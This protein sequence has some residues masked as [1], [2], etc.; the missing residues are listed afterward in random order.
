MTTRHFASRQEPLYPL[1]AFFAALLLYVL[2]SFREVSAWTMPVWLTLAF[3][4]IPALG[5]LV[6]GRGRGGTVGDR[7]KASLLS[8]GL[9]MAIYTCFHL[10]RLHRGIGSAGGPEVFFVV[11][12]ISVM[13]AVGASAVCI[14]VGRLWAMAG[15]ARAEGNK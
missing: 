12:A 14:L 13:Y 4:V 5:A 15:A 9:S 10:I 2:I 7:V 8:V 6:L 3:G 1:R 11:L